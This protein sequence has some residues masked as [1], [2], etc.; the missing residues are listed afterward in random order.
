MRSLFDI[1][2]VHSA[3]FSALRP[4]GVMF[5]GVKFSI[6]CYFVK[7]PEIFK[8]AFNST[9][10]AA[11]AAKHPFLQFGCLFS[12]NQGPAHRALEYQKTPNESKFRINFFSYHLIVLF[13][14]KHETR[15]Q[16]CN[17][18]SHLLMEFSRSFSLW[19]AF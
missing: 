6:S 18:V 9:L 13:E 8:W 4:S 15:F 5:R 1:L 11:W 14:T 7:F 19:F 16:R 3:S 12:C 10:L 2:F 17:F